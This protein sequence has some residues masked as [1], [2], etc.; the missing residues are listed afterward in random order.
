MKRSWIS[1]L[2]CCLLVWGCGSISWAHGILIESIPSHGAILETSPTVIS[3]R[4]NAAL[5]PS[6]SQVLLVDLKNHM[7]TLV[8]T[9]ESTVERI[10]ATVPLLSPGV[11]HVK[12]QV[13]AIDGH[14]TEGSIRFTILAH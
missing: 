5:E 3:L 11:Y 10:V 6:I 8:I 13:L 1:C 12:Y 14:V 9:K 4:F 7:Q 2:T